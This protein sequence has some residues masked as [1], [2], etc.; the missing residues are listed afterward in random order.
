MSH[1]GL[2]TATLVVVLSLSGLIPARGQ[3]PSQDGQWSAPFDLPLIAIH[4]AV[5][6]TGKVLMFSAE[7]GVPG[8]HGWVLDPL[9]F[10]ERRH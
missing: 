3:T 7:H 5:L 8:I 9:Q 1:K 2:V 4:S 10:P 6:P